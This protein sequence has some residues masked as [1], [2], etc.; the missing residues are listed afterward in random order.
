[1][2][3]FFNKNYLL[4]KFSLVYISFVLLTSSI[5]CVAEEGYYSSEDKKNLFLTMIVKAGECGGKF[6]QIPI[7]PIKKEIP[8]YAV[9]ACTL[10]IIQAPCPVLEYPLICLEIFEV[11]IPNFGPKIKK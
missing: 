1:M 7:F 5:S 9:Q 11:D 3:K 6:P 10:A 8:L 2:Q 4:Q